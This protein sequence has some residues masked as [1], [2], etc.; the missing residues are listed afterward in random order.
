MR[1]ISRKNKKAWVKVIE[2]FFSILLVMGIIFLMISKTYSKKNISEKISEMETSIVTDIQINSSLRAEVLSASVPSNWSSFNSSGLS[3]VQN[4]ILGSKL[5][6]LDCEAKICSTTD[7]C[8][9]DSTI[10]KD[11]YAESVIIAADLTTYNPRQLKIFC[12]EK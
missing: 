9:M 3:G 12:W 6:G 7:I 1:K 5:S 8:F 10:D 11:V 4:K 2:V